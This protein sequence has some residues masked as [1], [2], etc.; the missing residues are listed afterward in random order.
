V[1]GTVTQEFYR[2]TAARRAITG[3]SWPVALGGLVRRNRRRYGGYTAHFGFAVM[4][5]GVAASSS[6]QHSRNATLRPGQSVSNDGYAF[7][8]VRPTVA[9]T[10]ERISFGAVIDVTKKGKQVTRLHTMQSFYPSTD[11]STGFIGR[12]FDSANA[13]S[14]IGLDAGARRDIWTVAAADLSA[15][16][17]LINQGNRL[18]ANE[19]NA[20]V[21][22][23]EKLPAAEQSAALNQA[24]SV[25]R[26]WTYRD[27]AVQDI[28]ATYL[29]HPY[30]IQFLLIVAPLVTW[31]WIGAL[32]IV[33]GGLISLIPAGLFARRRS[34]AVE[35]SR[36]AA[37]ELV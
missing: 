27:R 6:F 12:F 10:P 30:P 33:L 4:L 26:F 29:K 11:A 35:R 37:R 22:K 7:H 2:G 13:D 5:I 17:P 8:Y 36:V 3:A 14:T 9:T 15:L 25:N 31:L 21:R 32:I 19:Y 1:I 34:P 20:M 28:A 23:A 24:I 18:F 16:G